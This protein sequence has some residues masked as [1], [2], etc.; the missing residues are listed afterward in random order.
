MDFLRAIATKVGAETKGNA[1][2][3]LMAIVNRLKSLDNPFLIFD[4]CEYIRPLHWHLIKALIQDLKGVCGVAVCGIIKDVLAKMAGRDK[5]GFPQLVRRIGHS[6]V[7]MRPIPRKEIKRFATDN[8]IQDLRVVDML[9][10]QAT[11][12]DTLTTQVRE[13]VGTSER[14]SRAITPELYADLFYEA[15]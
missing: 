3:V 6:W 10:K 15:A 8:S 9:Y 4:E 13:L 11:D 1:Y 5:A 14:F 2:K 12:Y 7:N